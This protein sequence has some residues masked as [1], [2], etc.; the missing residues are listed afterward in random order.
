MPLSTSDHGSSRQPST[1]SSQFPT[2]PFRSLATTAIPF[3]DGNDNG[4]ASLDRVIQ[5][6]LTM[7]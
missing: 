5:F 6:F 3:L 4:S 2:I 1:V 7:G